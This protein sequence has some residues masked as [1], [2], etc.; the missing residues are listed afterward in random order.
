MFGFIISFNNNMT[1]QYTRTGFEQLKDFIYKRQEEKF[2]W[3]DDERAKISTL[4]ELQ[5]YNKEMRAKF[6]EG[7]G[8]GQGERSNFYDPN[9]GEYLINRTTPDHDGCGG[10]GF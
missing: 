5:A 2:D 7:I 9:T 1:H 4:E 8:T 3:A 6:I 10:S